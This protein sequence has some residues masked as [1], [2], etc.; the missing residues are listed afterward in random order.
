V[1]LSRRR[2]LSSANIAGRRTEAEAA[3]FRIVSDPRIPEGEIHAVHQD[4]RRQRF[5]VTTGELISEPWNPPHHPIYD[6]LRD[7]Y[8]RQDSEWRRHYFGDFS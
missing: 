1:S 2:F 6:L 8:E 7:E 5:D 3:G 4:G